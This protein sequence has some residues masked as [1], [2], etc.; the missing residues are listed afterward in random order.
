MHKKTFALLPESP[1]SNSACAYVSTYIHQT[2]KLAKYPLYKVFCSDRFGGSGSHARG[3]LCCRSAPALGSA[4]S[5][6][7]RGVWTHCR[8][9]MRADRR[10]GA[11]IHNARTIRLRCAESGVCRLFGRPPG[12]VARRGG[13]W[14]AARRR[15]EAVGWRRPSDTGVDVR[16]RTQWS[17]GRDGGTEWR[18][19]GTSLAGVMDKGDRQGVT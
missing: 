11:D 18:D 16:G 2:P 7:A 4:R 17:S 6:L 19:A 3:L 13:A 1:I 9:A 12:G 8:L 14:R 10:R 5:R 15:R